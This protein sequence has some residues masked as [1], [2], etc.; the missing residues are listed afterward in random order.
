M[1]LKY[2]LRGVGTGIL[3]CAIILLAAYKTSPVTLSDAEIKERAIEL[4]MVEAENSQQLAEVLKNSAEESTASQE[5]TTQGE[6]INQE[7]S[8]ENSEASSEENTEETTQEESSA[9]TQAEGVTITVKSGMNSTVV[10]R[11][12]MDAGLIEDASDFDKYLDQNGYSTKIAVGEYTFQIGDSYETIAK[13][14]T[15]N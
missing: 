7:A 14:I 3:F 1:K 9:G 4:G 8:T 2:Y 5:N 11:L 10:A 13:E 6:D 12:C 15:G